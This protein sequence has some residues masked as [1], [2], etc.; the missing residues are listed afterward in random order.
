MTVIPK[1]AASVILIRKSEDDAN[2]KNFEIY[3]TKRAS[4]LRSY[5][6]FHVFPG[7][8]LEPGDFSPEML[9]RCCG[10]DVDKA[11][12]I[13]AQTYHPMNLGYWVAAVR[14]LFEETGILLA[15]TTLGEFVKSTGPQY[16]VYY[17]YRQQ[18]L[19]QEISFYD[20]LFAE[21]L[22]L[23]V[24]KLRYFQH[25]I[26]PDGLPERYDTRFFLAEIPEQQKPE[27]YEEEI[28][29]ALWLEPEKAMFK[30]QK[31][32]MVLSPPTVYN[33]ESLMQYKTLESLFLKTQKYE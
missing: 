13:L 1:P 18:M 32:E 7:G 24:G 16:E 29:E 11:S 21:S 3:M 20:M 28:T 25:R 27:P 4:G 10:L 30:W 12:H 31:Q 5:P 23:P 26:T 17:N 6:G 19:T 8:T 9:T 14:E 15:S 2:Y 22:F 33:L